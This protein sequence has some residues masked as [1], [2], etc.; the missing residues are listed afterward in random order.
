MPAKQFQ[1]TNGELQERPLDEALAKVAQAH[2]LWPMYAYREGKYLD[3]PRDA[4][5]R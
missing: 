2:L 1:Y 4:D 5:A 3:T